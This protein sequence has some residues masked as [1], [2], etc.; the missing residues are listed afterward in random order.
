MGLLEFAH[1]T[2]AHLG[3]GTHAVHTVRTTTF[4]DFFGANSVSILYISE[5]LCIHTPL[6]SQWNYVDSQG[7]SGGGDS[8][9]CTV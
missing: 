7:E 4:L 9:T 2:H 6:Y 5:H 1:L 3:L 8:R